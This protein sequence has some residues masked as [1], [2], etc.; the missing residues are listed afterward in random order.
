MGLE[1]GTRFH[2]NELSSDIVPILTMNQPDVC[3]YIYD[4]FNIWFIMISDVVLGRV[5]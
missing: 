5:R 1:M 2:I 3:V 4:L